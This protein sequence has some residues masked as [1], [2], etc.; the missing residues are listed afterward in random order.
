MGRAFEAWKPSLISIE[1]LFLE[2]CQN[3]KF[4]NKI[5]A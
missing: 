1:V 5:R 3:I 4:K 2:S